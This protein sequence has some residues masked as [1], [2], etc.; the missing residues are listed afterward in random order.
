MFLSVNQPSWCLLHAKE[1][2]CHGSGHPQA[3]ST[4]G[5]T[6]S[7]SLS[8]QLFIPDLGPCQ[9][10]AHRLMG[11]MDRGRWLL[12]HFQKE[13]NGRLLW[14]TKKMHCNVKM[15]RENIL[16]VVQLKSQM[17]ADLSKRMG[18]L[19]PPE[20]AHCLEASYMYFQLKLSQMHSKMNG[21][22]E[23]EKQWS[24]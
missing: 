6:A 23:T 22:V 18:F 15:P 20:N 11:T 21:E 9:N 17:T 13:S 16:P 4:D 24:M 2:P 8:Y 14:P 3:P 12:T 5:T 7:A 1:L 19:C 10:P